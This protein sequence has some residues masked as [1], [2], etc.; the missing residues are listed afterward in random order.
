M[1]LRP[2]SDFV[3]MLPTDL[4][5][6]ASLWWVIWHSSSDMFR[7]IGPRKLRSSYPSY[8]LRGERRTIHPSIFQSFYKENAPGL[9]VE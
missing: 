9:A 3:G 2:E 5:D 6:F 4:F 8:G 1:I 7:A